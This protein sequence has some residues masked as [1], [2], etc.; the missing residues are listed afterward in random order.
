MI[1][2]PAMCG[3]C[4]APLFELTV[5]ETR[6]EGIGLVLFFHFVG[7]VKELFFSSSLGR[8]SSTEYKKKKKRNSSRKF[9]RF[10]SSSS[11]SSCCE[12]QQF[13]LGVDCMAGF[14]RM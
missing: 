13:L 14:V 5:Q 8:I 11:S 1:G 12:N 9:F 2:G 4:M 7:Q 6:R 3:T 10:S